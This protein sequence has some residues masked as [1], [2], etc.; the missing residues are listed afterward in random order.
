MF[1]NRN[2]KTQ[3]LFDADLPTC[4]IS[5]LAS[6]TLHMCVCRCGV[7]CLEELGWLAKVPR[8]S[9]AVMFLSRQ[10]KEGEGVK[11]GKEREKPPGCCSLM[12]TTLLYLDIFLL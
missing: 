4:I 7:K 11:R 3:V 2:V 10:Q 9:V 1:G 12:A 5:P 8:F 6:R